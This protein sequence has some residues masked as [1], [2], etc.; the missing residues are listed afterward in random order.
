MAISQSIQDKVNYQN[1][2]F[3]DLD[4]DFLQHP[5][6]KD[7]RKKVGEN[8]LKQSIRNLIMTNPRERVFQPEIGCG[9][10]NMLFE[11]L[12]PITA[13]EIQE[14]I[15]DVI[16]SYEPRVSLESVRVTENSRSDGYDVY[17]SFSIINS[18]Q[19]VAIDFFLERMR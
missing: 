15:K 1:R 3:K 16:N 10:Y 13:L 7:V 14:S 19:T 5:A 9:V 4:L 2:T 12:M 11:P 6:T 8:A 18:E 17:I